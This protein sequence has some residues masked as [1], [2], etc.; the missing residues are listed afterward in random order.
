MKKARGKKRADLDA[1]ENA[2]KSKVRSQIGKDE[3]QTLIHFGGVIHID[4]NEWGKAWPSVHVVEA[5]ERRERQEESVEIEISIGSRTMNFEM[6]R[7]WCVLSV[8]RV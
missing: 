5:G 4:V 2:E 3:K 8:R 7:R 1:K 6:S